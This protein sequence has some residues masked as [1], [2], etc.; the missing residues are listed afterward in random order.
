MHDEGYHLAEPCQSRGRIVIVVS[1]DHGIEA[2]LELDIGLARPSW[3][4]LASEASG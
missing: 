4:V 1:L 2:A 3:I